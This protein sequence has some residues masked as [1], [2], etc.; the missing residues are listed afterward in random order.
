[1]SPPIRLECPTF[2]EY[3]DF[4]TSPTSYLSLLN[5]GLVSSPHLIMMLY[6][7]IK[8]SRHLNELLIFQFIVAGNRPSMTHE[9]I[10]AMVIPSSLSLATVPDS[11]GNLSLSS[12]AKFHLSESIRCSQ[13]YANFSAS[14]RAGVNNPHTAHFFF[15]FLQNNQWSLLWIQYKSDSESADFFYLDPMKSFVD[16]FPVPLI[17][18]MPIVN[19]YYDAIDLVHTLLLD[20]RHLDKAA[21]KVSRCLFFQQSDAFNSGPFAALNIIYAL[22]KIYSN[23]NNPMLMPKISFSV[24]NQ[25]AESIRK[26]LIVYF[27]LREHNFESPIP[28]IIQAPTTK[29]ISA[30]DPSPLKSLEYYSE[31]S[32]AN[33]NHNDDQTSWHAATETPQP[34]TPKKRRAGSYAFI[35][36]QPQAL[37]QPDD[38][39]LQESSLSQ[40]EIFIP[41]RDRR[42]EPKVKFSAEFRAKFPQV[43]NALAIEH[44]VISTF[45]AFLAEVTDK[46]YGY[47]T[48][49][50][51]SKI[52]FRAL[53]RCWSDDFPPEIVATIE[54]NIAGKSFL[55][56][57]FIALATKFRTDSI[58]VSSAQCYDCFL[59]QILK[60][61]LLISKEFLQ[62]HSQE[63]FSQQMTPEQAKSLLLDIV[64]RN[65]SHF[66][67]VLHWPVKYTK[68]YASD[69]GELIRKDHGAVLVSPR[70]VMELIDYCF[71]HGNLSKG[72]YR[73]RASRYKV[74]GSKKYY[75]CPFW[76]LSIATKYYGK[77]ELPQ[78][79][80]AS[81]TQDDDT[82]A[83]VGTSN[84]TNASTNSIKIATNTDSSSSSS[85]SA[86]IASV[87]PASR[88]K[89]GF[90]FYDVNKKNFT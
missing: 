43:V 57:E 64:S 79:V 12:A 67:A 66:E 23:Q 7:K 88:K 45:Q 73:D 38:A 90:R 50:G 39:T 8:Y 14:R 19:G 6:Q 89:S 55:P 17:D 29:S 3:N 51:L 42:Q 13:L 68:S 44:L 59:N 84:A 31:V 62:Q 15:P 21:A 60:E 87:K 30:A 27:T 34:P 74:I 65:R 63:I 11:S 77:E 80:S 53:L 26:D 81:S 49:R 4:H 2:S 41:E 9:S 58:Y 25:E 56:A 86:S 54:A 24:S 47:E 40:K 36:P 28:V 32:A 48:I 22:S 37:H 82:S 83:D 72:N 18:T 52:R 5:C 33:S 69:R 1:M 61:Q 75:K 76:V 35:E 20:G 70:N 16:V 78:H 85:S 10:N 71:D 46:A